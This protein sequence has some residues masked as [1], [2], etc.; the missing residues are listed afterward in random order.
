MKQGLLKSEMGFLCLGLILFFATSAFPQED[1]TRYP[2]R[3]IT[4]VEPFSPGG[5]SD[6]A[7]RSLGKAVEKYLGQPIVITNK[8]GGGG[9]V[10]VAAIAAAKPD[11]YTIGQSAGGAPL[12]ILPFLE[13]LPYHP[14]NDLRYIVQYSSPSFGIV[15]KGDSPFKEFKD[16]IAYARQNPR[17]VAYG[18]NA[19]NSMANLIVEQVAKKEGVQ[20][21]HIPFKA[22]PEYQSALL[23]GHVLFTAGDFNHA[24]LEA[25]QTRLLV[26][27]SD[28]RS[29]EYPNAPILKDLGYEISVPVTLNVTA[30]K[31]FPDEMARKLEEAFTKAMKEHS[32]IK[33]MKDL[34]LTIIHRNSRELTEYVAKNYDS[35]GKLLKDLGVAK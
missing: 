11:G 25:G 13:K 26:Y 29:E 18:T 2:S 31:D 33:V 24:L 12:F 5:S 8:P 30:P 15:V 9:S 27:L 7:M 32:F 28:K 1:I 20:F 4:F 35:F 3:P 14:V 34:R 10:G 6:L 22:S 17:K 23:G 21:T 19:P 16:L